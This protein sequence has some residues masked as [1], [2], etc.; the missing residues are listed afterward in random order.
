MVQAKESVKIYSDQGR[1]ANEVKVKLGDKIKKGEVAVVLNKDE[2]EQ[3]IKVE[4]L[5]YDQM[6]LNLEKLTDID[7]NIEFAE[8][9]LETAKENLDDK[10]TLYNAGAVSDEEV[11]QAENA[12][13]LAERD[14]DDEKRKQRNNERDVKSQQDSIQLEELTIMKLQKKLNEESIL[15]SPV[16]GVINEL[17]VTKGSM[18]NGEVP[19]FSVADM[20]KGFETRIIVD[21]EKAEY[22]AVGDNV[23]INIKSLGG[24]VFS[25]RIREIAESTLDRGGKKDL[26][27]DVPQDGV[28]GGERCDIYI[29]K[30][31]KVYNMLISNTAV[32]TDE[33]GKFV[34]SLKERKGPLGSEFYV[35]R[36]AV[37]V[38][39]SDSTKTAVIN[40]ISPDEYIVV[41]YSK[42][43]SDGGRVLPNK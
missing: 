7:S 34:W 33:K 35:Q 24:D 27:I 13:L 43:L 25:G 8:R 12:L 26:L 38:D 39:D 30:K 29:N 6:K 21:R 1:L 5:R 19:V 10:R 37:T 32:G 41:G 2:I 18:V 36:A 16:D 14:L 40:G 22:L 11:K 15:V 28:I 4:M 9:K 17:N 31:T 42:S 23:D 3:Q 20:S